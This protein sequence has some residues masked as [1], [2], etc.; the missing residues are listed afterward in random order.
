MKDAP[1]LARHSA[2][3]KETQAKNAGD[4]PFFFEKRIV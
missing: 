4:V 2:N 1:I 3:V